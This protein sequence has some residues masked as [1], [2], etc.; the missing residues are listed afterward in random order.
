MTQ[1]YTVPELILSQDS[2]Y[3][4]TLLQD[5]ATASNLTVPSM[6]ISE[7]A[8]LANTVARLYMEE[9]AIRDRGIK[10]L[11][12]ESYS[13]ISELVTIGRVPIAFALALEFGNEDESISEKVSNKTKRLV[14]LSLNL[15]L[16]T[17]RNRSHQRRENSFTICRRQTFNQQDTPHC[18]RRY[19]IVHEHPTT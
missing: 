10:A 13:T 4:H 14:E 6:F 18:Y 15:R 11:E 2:N 17:G 8:V 1:E 5:I 7:G 19:P 12:E 3:R 16:R 9:D